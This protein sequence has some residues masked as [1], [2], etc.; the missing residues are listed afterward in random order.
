MA[1]VGYEFFKSIKIW[2]EKDFRKRITFQAVEWVLLN[3]EWPNLASKADSDD[4]PF[5]QFFVDIPQPHFLL[6]FL[7]SIGI[8][9]WQH[10]QKWEWWFHLF[11]MKFFL[12]LQNV[13]FS[14]GEL[15]I[16]QIQPLISK[17]FI[18]MHIMKKCLSLWGCSVRTT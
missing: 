2:L 7:C 14:I 8:V 5:Q 15:V 6:T 3:F 1:L 17:K 13:N 16:F 9:P 11:F 18:N 10:N 12:F 4:Q